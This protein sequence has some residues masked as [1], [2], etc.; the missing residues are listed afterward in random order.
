LNLASIP[1]APAGTAGSS[2]SI[3]SSGVIVPQKQMALTYDRD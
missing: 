1:A 2:N 3:T